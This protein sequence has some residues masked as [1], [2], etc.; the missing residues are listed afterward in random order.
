MSKCIYLAS[1]GWCNRLLGTPCDKVCDDDE[2]PC[3]HKV[4]EKK[5]TNAD[6]VRAM[7]DEELAHWYFTA[8]Y[9]MPQ[10]NCSKTT[11][12]VRYSCKDCLL[13][14]LKQEVHDA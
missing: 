3:K 8:L 7:S 12:C 1:D 13:E 11:L 2:K 9:D 6:R 14:W 4:E 10:P 5:K